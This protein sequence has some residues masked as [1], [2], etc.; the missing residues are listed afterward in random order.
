VL[1]PPGPL[2]PTHDLS[3]FSCGHTAL[4]DWLRDRA[5]KPEGLSGRT[6]VV[7]DGDRVI[8][9]YTLATGSETHSRLP[10]KLKRNAPDPVPLLVLARLAVDTEFQG[11]GVGPGLLKDAFQRSIQAS[12]IAGVRALVVH[13]IDDK[14]REFYEKFSFVASP[15]G[16]RTL[17][18]PIETLR[19]A[20]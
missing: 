2:L 18:L 7:G 20:L 19:Q 14:A 13:A 3:S 17:V 12:E 6:Y 11:K 5:Q 4:D 16:S 9:Y 10:G 1:K 15:A 8:G